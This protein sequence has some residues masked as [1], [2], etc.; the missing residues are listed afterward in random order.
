MYKSYSELGAQPES[1]RDQYNVFDVSTEQQ[2]QQILSQTPVVCVDIYADWCQPC[3]QTAPDYSNLAAKYGKVGECALIK[4]N[5]DKKF[6][7]NIQGVPTFRFYIYGQQVDE[8][9]GA[10]MNDVEKKIQKC[11]KAAKSQSFAQQPSQH[12]QSSGH[13]SMTHSKGSGMAGG[14]QAGMGSY[15]AASSSYGTCNMPAGG[16]TE[17]TQGPT[18]YGRNTIR[19]HTSPYHGQSYDTGNIKYDR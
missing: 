7:D 10:D 16:S 17:Y 8:T 5:Y 4:E 9:V 14:N 11:L 3:K 15:T 19:K 6:S 13:P 12:S 18:S 2:K 1:N